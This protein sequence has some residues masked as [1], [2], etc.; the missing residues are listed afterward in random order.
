MDLVA[1]CIIASLYTSDG[2][3]KGTTFVVVLEGEPNPPVSITFDG[4]AMESVPASEVMAAKIVHDSLSGLSIVGVT[5]ERKSFE[6]VIS[7]FQRSN[8][9]LFYLHEEGED[10]RISKI[11][12]RP[13]FILGDQKGLD[14]KSEQLLESMKIKKISLGPHPYLASHCI[15]VVNNELDIRAKR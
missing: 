14:P 2:P 6:G 5:L 13:V 9:Q 1:R 12:E 11:E 15:T 4:N 10:S 3:R 8:F 7:N